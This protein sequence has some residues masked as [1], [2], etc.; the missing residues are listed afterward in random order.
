MDVVWQVFV[1]ESANFV[2]SS[3][4]TGLGD[5]VAVANGEER[6]TGGKI[7]QCNAELKYEY[8]SIIKYILV[9]V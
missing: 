2:H 8:N 4:H 3:T 5:A 7:P 6:G 1:E 9:P